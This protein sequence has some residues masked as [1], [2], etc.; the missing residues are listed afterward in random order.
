MLPSARRKPRGK[1]LTRAAPRNSDRQPGTYSSTTTILPADQYGG[2]GGTGNYPVTFTTAG[3]SVTLSA[4][5]TTNANAP[6]PIT[7]FGYW[8]SAT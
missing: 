7:Y 2:A 1:R 8:L 4:V 3:Y 6:V 5:D